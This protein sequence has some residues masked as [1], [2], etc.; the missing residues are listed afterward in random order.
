MQS[1]KIHIKNLGNIR[2]IF[3]CLILISALAQTVR[4]DS[5]SISLELSDIHY[6]K[7]ETGAIKPTV[8]VSDSFELKAI[9]SGTKQAPEELQIKGLEQFLIRG[10]SSSSN[11][12]INNSSL[13]AEKTTA[14][15]MLPRQVGTFVIGPATV[16]QNGKTYES[17]TITI[18]V[19][20]QSDTQNKPVSGQ[21]NTS[22]S[23]LFCKLTAD[24]QTAVTEEPITITISIVR[25]EK[26]PRIRGLIPPKFPNCTVKEIE[27]A[28]EYRQKKD[29]QTVTVTQKQYLIFPQKTGTLTLQPAQAVYTVQEKRNNRKS[30][31]R[32]F[33]NDFF[34]DFF[35]TQAKQKVSASNSLSLT[36]K[37]LPSTQDYVD[38]VGSFRS[39]TAKID[40]TTVVANEPI[41][42]TLELTGHAN[43]DIILPPKLSL[44][45][46]FKTYD[47][48]TELSQD[49]THNDSPGVK[50][51]EFIFQVPESG[52]WEI[53]AQS[54]HYFD[55]KTKKYQ[56]MQTAP[57]PITVSIPYGAQ[58]APMPM[59]K[60]VKAT[61]PTPTTSD[62]HFIEE[63]AQ[64][65]EQPP[66]KIPIWGF[67]L[68]LLLIPVLS[69]LS[70]RGLALTNR[71]S[72][73]ALYQKK[74]IDLIEYDEFEKL[75]SLFCNFFAEN[76]DLSV[77][78][79]NEETITK[80]LT[81][82][83]LSREKTDSFLDFLNE[84]AH[85]SFASKE[86]TT[87]RLQKL[88]KKAE[89]WLIVI[90]KTFKK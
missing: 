57:I 67:A 32:F 70:P 49:L 80:A 13:L 83:D 66:T 35:P 53:P 58:S 42:F 47:S 71:K 26:N 51:F 69:S 59:P 16:N 36:I 9:V 14:Y 79:V 25:P 20:Q 11:I 18:L 10:Q 23:D 77:S 24:K 44:P 89:Y 84:C 5:L 4:C 61:A 63:H 43:F 40:K 74:L 90:S 19:T 1:R 21:T 12:S 56:T 62:I 75:Y 86:M 8:F 52:K 28:K 46:F 31:F 2:V 76:S 65:T 54:L 88:K 50:S 29:G 30:G 48:K 82:T 37:D 15:T 17:N 7:D 6:I 73:L 55:T 85:Y 68:L 38:A 39:F 87:E 64:A 34:S 41:K 45:N 81:K 72:N 22:E 27:H 33:D 60:Q 78:M 3:F